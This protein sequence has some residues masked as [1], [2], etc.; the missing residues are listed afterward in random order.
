MQRL[1]FTGGA[2]VFDAHVDPVEEE[3]FGGVGAWAVDGLEMLLAEPDA[4]GWN[5]GNLEDAPL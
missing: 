2:E 1:F 3:G 5:G 4:I